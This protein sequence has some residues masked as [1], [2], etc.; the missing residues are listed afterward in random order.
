MRELISDSS[1]ADCV[2][3]QVRPHTNASY[4]S[5]VARYLDTI[6]KW[7]LGFAAQHMS[8]H[9]NCQVKRTWYAAAYPK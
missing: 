2:F 3:L 5:F 6:A 8:S 7:N 1:H 9:L 4:L